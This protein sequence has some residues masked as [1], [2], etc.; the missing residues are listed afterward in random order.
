ME[1]VQRTER[2]DW[3]ALEVEEVERRLS[4]SHAGLDTAEVRRRRERFGPNRLPE[5]AQKSDLVI[6]LHQFTS[7]LIY[8]LLIASGVTFLLGHYVDAAVI[9]AAVLLNALIGFPQERKA[10]R[11]VR[12]LMHLVAPK[13]RVLRDGH[14]RE[15]ESGEL[16]PG[17]RVLLESGARVPADLRLAG[18]TGLAI[19][20]SMLT[21]ESMPAAKRIRTLAEGTPLGDRANLAFTGT[22]VTSGRG[23]GYVVAIGSGTELGAIAGSI[24]HEPRTE[25]PLQIRMRRFA[26]VITLA[27]VVSALLAF[28]VG[29]ALGERPAE[30]FLTAV[31]LAVAAIPEGLPVVFT[32]ALAVGVRR[33]ARRKAIVR[34][35]PAVETLGSTTVI[36]SDKTGT[37][38]ENRMTVLALWSGG[39]ERA[40]E[41]IPADESDPAHLALLAGVLDNEAEVYESEGGERS[42]GDPTEV[43]LLVA[44]AHAGID[45]E[46]ARGTHALFAQIPFESERRYSATVR[47]RGGHHRLWVKGAPERVLDMC[48]ALQG[49]G[50]REPLD[51][52]RV[53]AAAHEMAG[54]GLRVLA[55]A[56]NDVPA[57]PAAEEELPEPRD[58]ALLGLVGLMDPPREG[59][60]DAIAAVRSAGVRVL[61]ITGDHASTARAIGE[62]LGLAEPGA[63]VLTGGELEA[64]DEAALRGAVGQISIYARMAPDHKLRVVKALQANGEVVAVTGDGVNDAPALRAADIGVAMGR[65]GT[66]VAREAADLVLTTDDFVSIGAA[67]EQGR[68]TFDNVRKV[69]FFLVSTGLASVLVILAAMALRWP[70]PL[71]PAQLLWLNLVTKGLQDVSLAFEPGDPDLLRRPPRSRKEGIVSR[72]LWERT[73]IVGVV[74][75]VGTLALFRWE[76]D[77]TGSLAEA[78]TIALTALVVYSMFHVGNSRSDHRSLFR[79]SP[80]SNRFL[81]VATGAALVLHVL[82]LYVG[83]TQFVLRVV[84]L[85][86]AAWLRIFLVA[87]TIVAAVELHKLL[88]HEPRGLQVRRRPAATPVPEERRA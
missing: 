1:Q 70:L 29:V 46:E 2:T 36:G 23:W 53:L 10:E 33:M 58:L 65:S 40:L 57:P 14:E 26:H 88:R 78:Q 50:G 37:L 27:V 62:R 79:L 60:P 30:M 81:L 34:R 6:L 72:L 44:G 24:E 7:P 41:E 31:A 74:M 87:L 22:V 38:T 47:E 73:V 69:T 11:S 15:V 63:A 67:V 86:A 8:I 19:D 20:E 77:R 18:A 76:L 35:L 32:I 66:D 21:G 49:R 48:T 28:G 3:Y 17:D 39:E 71:L 61:M 4:A 16:V 12:A 68:I 64:L 55:F 59:V 51:R 83:P 45:H 43:A 84:P 42:T 56:W 75:A 80:F 85:D 82:A 25:T 54:R 13:A 5:P 9:L 52:E